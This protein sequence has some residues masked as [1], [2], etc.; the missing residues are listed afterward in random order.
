MRHNRRIAGSIPVLFALLALLGAPPAIASRKEA[1]KPP[2]HAAATPA[3]ADFQAFL[4]RLW[5]DA[6]KQG[7]ARRTFD[8]AFSG[9]SPDPSIVALTKKQSE[10]VKPIWSY[11]DS[12]IS[13]TRL[14]RGRAM[15]ERYAAELAAIERKYGVDRRIVLGIWGMETN[16]GSFT[17]DKDVIRSLATLAFVRYRDDFFRDELL[18]ALRML[19]EGHVER[20]AMRGSWAGAMGQTQFMPSSFMK[21]AVDFDGDG[22]KDVWGTIPDALASTANYL[23]G[24]GWQR[25]QPWGLEVRLPAGFDLASANGF[26][27]FARWSGAGLAGTAGALPRAGQAMLYLPAGIRGPALLV[28]ENYRVI[29]KYNSSDAYALAVAHLGDRIMGGGGFAADWPRGDKRLSMAEVKEI[30]RHLVRMGLPVGK[31]DGRI[32]EISRESVRKAQIRH[33]LPADGYPTLAL[34]ARLRQKP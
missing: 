19:E 18:V 1:P 28:T 22:A 29:K 23:A 34:L 10:F 7:I 25:G 26:T 6:Q 27:D 8:L 32:G 21:Y 33:G 20:R 24:H 3:K 16:F 11:L 15:A 4:A 13:A 5:A 17:G 12:A 9:V 2:G 31:I 14:E 30:Q